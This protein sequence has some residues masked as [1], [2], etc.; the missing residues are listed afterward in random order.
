M[1]ADVRVDIMKCSIRFDYFFDKKLEVENH[2]VWLQLICIRHQWSDQLSADRQ[3]KEFRS[4]R[5]PAYMLKPII[6][7]P[8][9]QVSSTSTSACFGV[10]QNRNS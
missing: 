10:G 5:G 4:I 1:R 2:F 7:L 8:K 9:G 6:L 3:G